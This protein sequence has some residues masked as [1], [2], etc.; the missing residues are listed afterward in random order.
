V[1]ARSP[2]GVDRR[3]PPVT[4]PW[5]RV[6]RDYA[7]PNTTPSTKKA[8]NTLSA[9]GRTIDIRALLKR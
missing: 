4:T 6:A 9:E 7:N 3:R 1:T 5:T 8:M 2:I